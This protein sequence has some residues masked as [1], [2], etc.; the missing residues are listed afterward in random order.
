MTAWRRRFTARRLAL[1]LVVALGIIQLIPVERTN[2]PVLA[3]VHAPAEVQAILRGACYDCHSHETRWPWYSRVAPVSWMVT[4]HVKEGRGDL[5]FSDWPRL[6]F[7]EQE[8][9]FKDIREQITKGK[10]PLR[11]YT[12][13]H[14]EARLSEAQRAALVAWAASATGMATGTGEKDD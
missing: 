10:M 14:R 12:W 7:E 9:A 6:D 8:H 4:H 5:N 1:G 11:G 2:P 3:D 13:M